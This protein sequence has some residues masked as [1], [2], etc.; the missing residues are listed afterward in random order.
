MLKSGDKR[1]GW[2]LCA[3]VL[4]IMM[5]AITVFSQAQTPDINLTVYRDLV[6]FMAPGEAQSWR[7]EV[8]SPSGE[9]LFDSD[10]VTGQ[11]LDWRLSGQSD[12]P[13]ESGLYAYTITIKN[14]SGNVSRVHQQG[15][16]IVDRAREDLEMAP[17]LNSPLAGGSPGKW[18][19]DQT[20]KAHTINTVAMGI[21]TRTPLA[22][23]HVGAGAVAPMTAGSTLLVE[24]GAATGMVLKSTTGAE[25]FFYQDHRHGLLGTASQHPLGIRTNNLNRLWIARDGNIGIHTMN[26][27]SPL[28][29]AGMIEVTSGGI[30]FPDGTIQTT[31]ANDGYADGV[32]ATPSRKLSD[33]TIPGFGLVVTR[34]NGLFNKVNLAAGPGIA[35]TSSLA[36]NTL[37]ISALGGGSSWLLA[38]NAGTTPATNFLGTTDSQ[39][40]VIRTN[41]LE[42]MRVNTSGNV[43]IGTT[44]I[45]AKLKVVGNGFDISGTPTGAAG[46]VVSTDTGNGL[47]AFSR[48]LIGVLGRSINADGV[49][50]QSDSGTP[51]RVQ[52]GCAAPCV[53]GSN[54][55]TAFDL[56]G[57]PARFVV[58]RD[59]SVGVDAPNPA[60]KLHV[61]GPAG[62]VS[63]ILAERPATSFTQPTIDGVNNGSGSGVAGRAAA[64]DPGSAGVIGRHNGGRPGVFGCSACPLGSFP[65]TPA[66]NIG[67]A[68]VAIGGAGSV[69]VLAQ[70]GAGGRLFVGE[71][72]AG[73]A[74]F[75]VDSSGNLMSSGAKS[76]VQPHPT[77][78]VKEIVYVA[79]EGSEAG[80]YMRGTA[81][82]VRGRAVINLP[83]HFSLVT[84]DQG[85][86]VQLTPLG[87]ALQLYVV[88]KSARQIIVRE[89]R[90]RVGQFDYLVQGLRKGF[91]NHQ[92]IR[93]K[94]K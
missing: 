53:P 87:Q 51:L 86:T 52:G 94:Q 71:S 80:T 2:K 33:P 19:V 90:G 46:I 70:A 16:V 47:S 23:L 1:H 77:D 29:V 35:I 18:D 48:D 49:I 7:V 20:T 32:G 30:K 64:D 38:G 50:A 54:L 58:K 15:N 37:T 84:N 40:L 43:G 12:Q 72:P 41:N 11:V 73:T 4:W 79:L 68:G 56:T 75:T 88:R 34:L 82:I 55:I 69:A 89:A 42:A 66:G 61:V 9:K 26:P 28:T 3:S 27:G 83:E 25:M 39:P 44:G 8:F 21:G 22:R 10:F 85:L 81:R 60:A 24:E 13:L 74:K 14:A 36:T 76:F 5:A 78:P 17:P 57:S 67:V 92:V 93:D 6:R 62:P 63:A 45:T 59:G 91:E 31:A 65:G